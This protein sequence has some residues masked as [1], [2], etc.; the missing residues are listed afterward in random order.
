MVLVSSFGIGWSAPVAGTALVWVGLA[1]KAR[2]RANVG[3]MW[4]GKG[5]IP[6]K[7]RMVRKLERVSFDTAFIQQYSI[8]SPQQPNPGF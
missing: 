8:Q 1:G 7:R 6:S 3:L 2:D 4:A 5:D